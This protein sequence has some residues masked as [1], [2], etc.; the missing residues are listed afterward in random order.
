MALLG[1]AAGV[2]A[3]DLVS[4]GY[5][6]TEARRISQLARVYFGPTKSTRKQRE[7]R[8]DAARFTLNML[9]VV[10]QYVRRLDDET[11]AWN[12]R[13][14][15]SRHRGGI[16]SL[17]RAARQEVARLNGPSRPSASRTRVSIS[18]PSDT[19]DRTLHLTGPEAR[20]ANIMDRARAVAAELN[21]DLA[22]AVFH[23]FENGTGGKSTYVPRVII[24]L[25][26]SARVLGGEAGDDI[27]LGTTN[28]AQITG[29]EFMQLKL[30]DFFECVLVDP[31]RGPISLGTT[32][33]TATPKQRRMLTS[34]LMCAEP[35]CSV[36]ADRCQVGHVIPASRGGPTDLENLILLCSYHNGVNRQEVF[37]RKRGPATARIRPDGDEEYNNHPTATRGASRIV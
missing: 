13:R 14:T 24:P 18:N 10:E 8:T 33:R 2:S 25:D 30:A 19:L 15:L 6:H 17:R 20:V 9:E 3:S 29:A 4:M 22:E 36:P 1:A 7:A 23:L 16:H 11:L 37:Y 31:V 26:E 28:G 35:G 27:I 21:L 5:D 12:L 34:E 32:R